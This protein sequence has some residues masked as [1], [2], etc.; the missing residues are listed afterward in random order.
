MTPAD[1]T[2]ITSDAKDLIEILRALNCP[3]GARFTAANAIEDLVGKLAAQTARAEAAEAQV[4]DLT[5]KLLQ[6]ADALE[7]SIERSERDMALIVKCTAD[8]HATIKENA[9][10][11]AKL[12]AMTGALNEA[13]Y[14]LSWALARDRDANP[15]YCEDPCPPVTRGLNAVRAALK[16]GGA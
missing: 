2:E 3:T 10:L 1:V 13:Q 9:V 7:A 4:A 11:A 15:P 16:T 5:A 14:G 6:A 8:M 12:E